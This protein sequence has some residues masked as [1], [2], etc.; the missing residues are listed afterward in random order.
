MSSPLLTIVMAF[1]NEGEEPRRTIESIYATAPEGSFRIIA[2]D[3]CSK[4]TTD[5]FEDLPAV[6]Y[7]RNEKRLGTH[8]SKHLGV[9]LAE[10]PYILMIDAHMRF[11]RDNW[12][13][14]LL[15]ALK[16]E[17]QTI[18]CTVCLGLNPDQQ[19]VYHPKARY[20]GATLE[21]V[22]QPTKGKSVAPGKEIFEAKWQQAKMWAT[23]EIPCVL[24]ANYA[25]SKAWFD[26]IHGL[27]GL[28]MWGSL[29]PYMSL[30]SWLAGGKCKILTRVEIGHIFRNQT[31]YTTASHYLYYNKLF[32]CHT[33]FPAKNRE[34][35][36][37]RLPESPLVKKHLKPWPMIGNLWSANGLITKKYLSGIS[38]G[39]QNDS[40]FLY[41]FPE[42]SL[43][44][45]YN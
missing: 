13:P 3:D 25:F 36:L 8:A 29:E 12:V 34:M 37:A 40:I 30:K 27:S 44:V 43:Q 38:P 7:V 6:R 24:G 23:Y 41:P 39:L 10:T 16:K 22:Q 33:L 11:K 5:R 28:K 4:Y 21:W 45:L 31:P 42:I 9:S 35:L 20:F 15:K 14:K 2:V 18:F 1:L 19:D 26:H 32:I 17:H